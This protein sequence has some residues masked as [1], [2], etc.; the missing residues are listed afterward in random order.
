MQ[1]RIRGI[2]P[3]EE[4]RGHEEKEEQKSKPG[5]WLEM[6]RQFETKKK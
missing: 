2:Q 6:M 3:R 1:G 5:E 4:V